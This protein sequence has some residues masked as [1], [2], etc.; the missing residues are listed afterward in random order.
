MHFSVKMFTALDKL[1]GATCEERFRLRIL[2][3]YNIN[4]V[5]IQTQGYLSFT[6]LN[7]KAVLRGK[8]GPQNTV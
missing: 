7:K 1:K 3:F 6:Q 5:M 4:R 2:T 8:I